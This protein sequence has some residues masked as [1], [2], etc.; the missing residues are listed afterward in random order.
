MEVLR[1]EY[2]LQLRLGVVFPHE[3]LVVHTHQAQVVD[4][5]ELDPGDVQTELERVH[6]E[7]VALA[8]WGRGEE[9]LLEVQLMGSF[10]GGES[11]EEGGGDSEGA[12]DAVVGGR[13][14]RISF[15]AALLSKLAWSGDRE[16][17]WGGIKRV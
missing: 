10:A 2:A 17:L 6:W 3:H 4:R 12:G 1:P 8:Q 14:S 7:A 11:S 5:C 13:N 9:V 16:G 15:I